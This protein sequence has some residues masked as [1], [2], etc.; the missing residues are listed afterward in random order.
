MLAKR[1]LCHSWECIFHILNFLLAILRFLVKKFYLR[2]Y[3]FTI[4]V[5]IACSV[6]CQKN[7]FDNL[8]ILHPSSNS[9]IGCNSY[10]FIFQTLPQ[11]LYL[12]MDF[13]VGILIYQQNH[14]QRCSVGESFVINFLFVGKSV[15]NKNI[16][17]LMD[18]LIKKVPK[19][20][21]PLHSVGISLGKIPYVIL[22]VII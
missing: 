10:N 12:Q 13:S 18:L 14:Q 17:L 5:Y 4:R 19:T 6:S 15:G 16:L 8:D 2:F 21:Y 3:D 22:S 20:I 9:L 11:S 1:K 7:V